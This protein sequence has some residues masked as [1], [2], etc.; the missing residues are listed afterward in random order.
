[1]PLNRGLVGL[2]RQFG[3]SD[4]WMGQLLVVWLIG[5]SVGELVDCWVGQ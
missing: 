3:W 4:S 1:M 2:Q 5:G